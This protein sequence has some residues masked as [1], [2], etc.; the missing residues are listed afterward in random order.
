MLSKESVEAFLDKPRR[1]YNYLKRYSRAELLDAIDEAGL[2]RRLFTTLPRLHQLVCYLIGLIER[3]WLF[4][5]DMGLGKTKI[6]LDLLTAAN[7]DRS[8]T[9]KLQALVFVP[10]LVHMGSWDNQVGEHSDHTIELV[11]DTS[12][13][14]KWELL[15]NSTADVTVVD[16]QGFGLACTR[17]FGKSGKRARDDGRVKLLRKKYRFIAFDEI[18]RCKNRDTMRFGIMRQ[19]VK[20]AEYIFGLSGTPAGRNPEDFW[21]EFFLVD[22]GETLGETLQMFRQAFFTAKPNYF[23]GTDYKFDKTQ[24]EILRRFLQNRSIAYDS[25]EC[26]D[27]PLLQQSRKLFTLTKEQRAAYKVIQAGKFIEVDGQRVRL[28][29]DG[30]FHRMREITSGYQRSRVNGVSVTQHFKDNPKLELLRDTVEDIPADCKFIVFYDYKPTGDM[31][32]ALMRELKIKALVLDGA[33]KDPLS[34]ERIFRGDESVR[35]LLANSA[36]GGEGI[37]AQRANYEIY[38]ESP[39]SPITRSQSIKR[40]HRDG[41]TRTVFA[42]DLVAEDTVDESILGFLAEGRDI[43]ASLM[44]GSPGAQVAL[45]GRG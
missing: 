36:S 26:L 7:K 4:F 40:A 28:P 6:V 17:A 2:P 31:L 14:R 38:F 35:A 1:S 11:A 34:I 25:A 5:L 10:K 44:Q 29:A 33:T 13:E 3:Y 18:H 30:A 37:N 12:I 41:Q 45:F 20:D 9:D 42:I 8:A 15:A 19:L 24:N 39:V 21:A 16:Y 22:G 23:G 27:L 32:Q 43:L